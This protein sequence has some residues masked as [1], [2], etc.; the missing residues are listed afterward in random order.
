MLKELIFDKLDQVSSFH[1]AG[2]YINTRIISNESY[3]IYL[4]NTVFH[5]P[6]LTF[7]IF[8]SNHAGSIHFDHYK[9][10][11]LIEY[12]KYMIDIYILIN[13]YC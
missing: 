4:C 8:Y 9:N 11:E 10:E 5:T 7:Y 1:G 6:D 12:K 2:N 13:I 3:N